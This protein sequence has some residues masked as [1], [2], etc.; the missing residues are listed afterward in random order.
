VSCAR[1]DN[2]YQ[3]KLLVNAKQYLGG[4]DISGA[5]NALKEAR[6]VLDEELKSGKLVSLIFGRLSEPS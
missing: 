5:K 1:T 3:Q 6:K 2:T 4:K